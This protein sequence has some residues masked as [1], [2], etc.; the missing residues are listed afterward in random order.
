MKQIFF[1]PI[2]TVQFRVIIQL[3]IIL[4]KIFDTYDPFGI[5]ILAQTL[6]DEAIQGQ[7]KKYM[8][9]YIKFCLTKKKKKYCLVNKKSMHRILHII[10]ISQSWRMF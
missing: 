8:Y 9:I 5:G 2:G 10:Y 7:K 3:I 4:E 6:A 1:I